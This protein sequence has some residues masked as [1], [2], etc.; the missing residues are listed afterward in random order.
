MGCTES[1]GNAQLLEK[2][3][4][5][6]KNAK[7]AATMA[8]LDIDRSSTGLRFYRVFAAMDIDGSNSIDLDELHNYLGLPRT[9]FSEQV[10]SGL[11]SELSRFLT[12][13][14]APD[15]V[16]NIWNFCTM[17]PSDL[18][19][20]V[21]SIYAKQKL[22]EQQELEQWIEEHR[23]H[24]TICDYFAAFSDKFVNGVRLE[25]CFDES[26]PGEKDAKE[27]TELR[28][29]SAVCAKRFGSAKARLE[30]I[31]GAEMQC[32]IERRHEAVKAMIKGVSAKTLLKQAGK[33]ALLQRITGSVAR[34]NEVVKEINTQIEK[35]DA[36]REDL[37]FTCQVWKGYESRV[38]AHCQ[39]AATSTAQR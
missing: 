36:F 2:Y 37:A 25:R 17:T 16:L 27:I 15:F 13:F 34:L 38:Q 5:Q 4:A 22:Q 19:K 12:I 14:V 6:L 32:T 29:S 10:F 33:Q 30:E 20:H 39:A 28:Y 18:F 3:A 26:S 35:S 8:A 21:F 7:V 24:P 9:T 23:R 31:W 11:G 1:K